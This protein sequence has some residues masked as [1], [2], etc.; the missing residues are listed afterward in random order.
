MNEVIA[1]I[2]GDGWLQA[3]LALSRLWQVPPP[4]AGASLCDW[5]RANG[6][7]CYSKPVSWSELRAFDLPAVL[8]L[9]ANQDAA[10]HVLLFGLSENEAM[11]L[12]DGREQLI[13]RAEL[14]RAW[15]GKQ[16]LLWR[17]PLASNRPIRLGQ[18]GERVRWLRDTLALIDGGDAS[19][20]ENE[21][22]DAALLE[23]VKAFQR[24]RGLDVDGIVGPQTLIQLNLMAS[25]DETPHLSA[26]TDAGGRASRERAVAMEAR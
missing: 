13:E 8:E 25:S 22:F 2:D 24:Q 10:V 16:V 7:D 23:R 4:S 11:V 19:S 14:E 21:R 26:A 18:S 3:V 5:A 15:R 12:V 1:A 17:P 6:L 9:S 20:G